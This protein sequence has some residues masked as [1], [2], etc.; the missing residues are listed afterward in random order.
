MPEIASVESILRAA[1][2][3]RI[4]IGPKELI[5]RMTDQLGLSNYF[6]LYRIA[7][8]LSFAGRHCD[9]ALPDYGAG[10]KQE[11]RLGLLDRSDDDYIF[12]RLF[13]AAAGK[14]L[15]AE[16]FR[17][18]FRNHIEDGLR[19]LFFK[20]DI[21]QAANP[22]KDYR[23]V[24]KV[25]GE[26]QAGPGNRTP[27]S[28]PLTAA[29]AIPITI[30]WVEN[31]PVTVELNNRTEIPAL[32][33]AITGTSGSG[34]TYF[35][36][37]LMTKIL[38]ASRLTRGA[39]IDP[40]GDIT[41]K[42][43]AILRDLDFR[44]YRL[45]LSDRDVDKGATRGLPINPF[46]LGDD[47][48]TIVE[49]LLAV[50]SEAV[51]QNN[52]VQQAI[53]RTAVNEVLASHGAR[54]AT[55]AH[56]ADAYLAKKNDKPDK[57]SNFLTSLVANQI[58]TDGGKPSDFFGQN[59]VISYAPD[60]SKDI[61]SLVTNLLVTL[62]RDSH[63]QLSEGDPDNVYRHINRVLFIDEAH[64]LS[65]MKSTGLKRLLREGRSFGLGLILA[66]Q[67]VNHFESL[68]RGV[69]LR[70]EIPMWFVLKQ[71][72]TDA[73]MRMLESMFGVTQE[74]DRRA[75]RRQLATLASATAGNY[76]SVTNLQD[77]HRSPKLMSLRAPNTQVLR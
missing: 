29:A 75:L 12:Y 28:M 42:Y 22:D 16:E 38:D 57:V 44:F 72:I 61:Q 46:L 24:L 76:Y 32:N 52:P 9:D 35:A 65:N 49:R 30:G 37:Q 23:L 62:F 34:K 15:S 17:D 13:C 71:T 45:A 51:F 58:F 53:F 31:Q 60:L 59:V 20:L 69:D 3:L 4:R 18:V 27:T 5:D 43:G 19:Y 14:R 6:E 7:A 26:L 50:F 55:I 54:E 36:V 33:M 40:K 56:L 63:Q 25:L 77:L 21:G 74:Q 64:N 8:A 67:H 47:T 48:N 10:E 41:D 66:S 11:I 39:I 70:E 2:Q 73:T 68:V 1:D